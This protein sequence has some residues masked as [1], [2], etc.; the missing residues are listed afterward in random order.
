MADTVNSTVLQSGG[1]RHIVQI[2]NISDGTGESAVIKVDRSTLVNN[3]GIE[4]A[5]MALEE[6]TWSIQGFTS[7]RLAWDHTA[8]DELVT[9]STGN[10]Y[11]NF[12]DIGCLQDPASAGGTGDIV[13]TTAGAVANATY[14]ITL[15]VR[16]KD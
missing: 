14:D 2:M 5:K 11:F 4:P 9:L 10:G 3:D 7:V 13:L 1:R 8:D 16:L 12:K 6:I 15:V